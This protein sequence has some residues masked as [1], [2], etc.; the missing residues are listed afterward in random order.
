[1]T[2]M[3]AKKGGIRGG[4]R[5]AEAVHS[6]EVTCACAED[7]VDIALLLVRGIMTEMDIG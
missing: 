3:Y 6:C 7:E 1:M 2:I 5:D 4:P